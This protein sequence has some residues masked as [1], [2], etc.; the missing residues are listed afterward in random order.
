MFATLRHESHSAFLHVC[1]CVAP[2]MPST[3]LTMGTTQSVFIE[4]ASLLEGTVGKWKEEER[5]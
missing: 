1:A 4:V 3:T 2:W 5:K